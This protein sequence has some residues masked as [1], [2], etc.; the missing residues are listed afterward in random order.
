MHLKCSPILKIK[1]H[2]STL[3]FY[4]I[5]IKNKTLNIIVADFIAFFFILNVAHFIQNRKTMIYWRP[6]KGK[7]H[8]KIIFMQF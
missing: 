5:E 6:I 2:H 4:S 8:E 3:S 7:S 1:N